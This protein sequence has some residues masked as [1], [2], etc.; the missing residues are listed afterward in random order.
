M[1]DRFERDVTEP[2]VRAALRELAHD[3]ARPSADR[4][5]RVLAAF[6]RAWA[7]RRP[8][9]SRRPP[10]VWIALAASLVLVVGLSVLVLLPNRAVTPAGPAASTPNATGFI[11]LPDAFG[12]PP[13][14][15]GQ[16]DRTDLPVSVLPSLGIA[17]PASPVT[18]VKA[19]VLVGQDGFARAVR[20]VPQI[21]TDGHR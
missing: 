13:L 11:T 14:E 18:T 3:P 16:L 6:D 2:E 1:S 4:E 10:M 7:G 21:A 8:S 5:A 17:P 20:L 19:D 9:P 12:L 15:S